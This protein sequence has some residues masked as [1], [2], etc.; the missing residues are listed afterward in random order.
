MEKGFLPLLIVLLLLASGCAGRTTLKYDAPELAQGEVAAIYSASETQV[1]Q[2]L[3]DY[4]KS[5]SPDA[6]IHARKAEQ[7]TFLFL[8]DEPAD[9]VD[10]GQFT[11][12]VRGG[13]H[14]GAE[15]FKAAQRRALFRIGADANDD[16]AATR[17]A[18]LKGIVTVEFLPLDENRTKVSVFVDYVLETE[19]TGVS[20]KT[21]KTVNVKDSAS[22]RTGAVGTSRGGS[23]TI[24]PE[25]VDGSWAM[26]CVSNTR[27]EKSI[28]TGINQRLQ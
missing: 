16:M 7:Y 22:F 18:A 23:A 2:A 1:K 24:N 8:A 20:D 5:V 17:T 6:R 4:I 14:P 25:N 28:L 9:Y 11:V 27:L 19:T 15:S 21:Q 26:Q 13:A 12:S 10:C 3:M